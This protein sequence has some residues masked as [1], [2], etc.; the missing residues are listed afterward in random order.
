MLDVSLIGTSGMMPLPN[1]WLTSM[2]MRYNGKMLLIDCGEGT[3][4]TLKLCGW[5]FKSIEVICFT[6]YHADHIS[7]LPGILL[8]ISNSGRTE[9]ITIIGPVGLKRVVD[10]LKVI[11]PDLPFDTNYVELPFNKHIC[12]DRNGYIIT[13][14]PAEHTVPCIAY[15]IDVPRKGKFDITRAKSNGIP[16]SYW[17]TLQ[18]GQNIEYE[19]KVFY[20][21]MVLG[22][23]RKGLSV[24]YC[25][26]TRPTENISNLAKDSDLFI[27]EGMYGED[28]KKSK[29]LENKHMLFSEAAKLAKTANVQELWLTH[30][31]PSLTKP[32]DFLSVAT[33]IF[34]NTLIGYDRIS[35]TLS[36]EE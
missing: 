10:S 25:T 9:P 36:F 12:Y 5:G 33:K 24:T 32:E 13:A 4:I 18:S 14:V 35:K 17:K 1:R 28:D 7:G 34:S 6:H 19:G 23:Q 27:C 29:A 22:E 30:F 21:H 26:D 2:V 15:R 3:Q 11:T 20:P 8:A 31:S 16:Q